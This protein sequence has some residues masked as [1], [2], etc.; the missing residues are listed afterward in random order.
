MFPEDVR[1]SFHFTFLFPVLVFFIPPMEQPP[2]HRPKEAVSIP[3]S[4]SA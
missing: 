2:V 4:A 1:K 3:F